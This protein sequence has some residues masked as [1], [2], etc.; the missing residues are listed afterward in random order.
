[1]GG[2]RQEVDPIKIATGYDGQL[3]TDCQERMHRVGGQAITS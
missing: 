3:V 2:V 1:M